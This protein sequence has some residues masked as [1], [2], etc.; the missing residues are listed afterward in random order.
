MQPSLLVTPKAAARG[1]AGGAAASSRHRDAPMY[2][3]AAAALFSCKCICS[4]P[5][6]GCL[7]VLMPKGRA[8]QPLQLA[9]CPRS[10]WQTCCC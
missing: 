8:S 1:G 5:W 10:L 2:S 7:F 9:S 3:S 6:Y 4:V